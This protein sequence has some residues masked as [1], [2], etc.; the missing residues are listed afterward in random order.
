MGESELRR[1]EGRSEITLDFPVAPRGLNPD[2]ETINNHTKQ[3]ASLWKEIE[4]KNKA[5]SKFNKDLKDLREQNDELKITVESKDDEIKALKEKINKLES[6]KRA[7]EANLRS[8]EGELEAVR[9]E[10]IGLQEA[11]KTS[12][13]RNAALKMNVKKLSKKMDGIAQNLEESRN[14]NST[15]K[16]EIKNPLEEVQSMASS[17]PERVPFGPVEKASLVLGELCWQIQAMM[18][19]RVLPNSYD[20]LKSYKV[21]HI[22]EDIEELKD[23]RQKDEAKKRWNALKKKLNWKKT[24]H[25]RAM[26]S[27][28]CTRNVAAHPELDEKLIVCSAKLMEQEG[29]LTDWHSPACVQEL[30]EMWK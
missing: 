30:I 2:S 8:V 18:Y 10:V 4:E 19:R 22:E 26:K 21:K 27:I 12:E 29:R 7:L 17:V 5:L 23:E 11:N 28:Q 13:E 6:E 24:H 3:I 25:T 15:L 16:M 14:E 1:M 20:K 9:K